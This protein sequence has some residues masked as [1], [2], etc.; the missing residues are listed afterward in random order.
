MQK[1][2]SMKL[3]LNYHIANDTIRIMYDR[4][5]V[6]IN[7]KFQINPQIKSKQFHKTFD[8]K[9]SIPLEIAERFLL[10]SAFYK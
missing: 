1:Y 7:Q 9:K 2:H 10:N 8:I 4:N 6:L 3:Y 5:K